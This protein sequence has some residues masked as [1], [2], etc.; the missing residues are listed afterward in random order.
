MDR[1]V[2]RV[3]A[4]QGH[5]M[6]L[7]ERCNLKDSTRECL[8]GSRQKDHIYGVGCLSKFTNKRPNADGDRP[9]ADGH[10]VR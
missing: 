2:Q 3:K 8:D 4:Y 5:L 9:C 6:H 10:L 7:H 1:E